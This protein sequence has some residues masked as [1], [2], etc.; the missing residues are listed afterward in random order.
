VGRKLSDSRIRA[1]LRQALLAEKRIPFE[2]NIRETK[3]YI[4]ALICAGTNQ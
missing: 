3:A 1:K 2:T 4:V